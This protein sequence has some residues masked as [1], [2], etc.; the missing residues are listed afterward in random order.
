MGRCYASHSRLQSH[1]SPNRD[2]K[3]SPRVKHQETKD[4]VIED[5]L[6]FLRSLDPKNWKVSVNIFLFISQFQIAC[7]KSYCDTGPGSLCR[8]GDQVNA[9]TSH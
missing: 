7:Y 9:N 4:L 6:D 2:A 3:P 5:D 1:S 8:V